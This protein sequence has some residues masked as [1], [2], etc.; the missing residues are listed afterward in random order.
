[1][2]IKYYIYDVLWTAP[3]NMS[4][5]VSVKVAAEN[6]TWSLNIKYSV[7][8]NLY[9]LLYCHLRLGDAV[10]KES[11]KTR[12]RNYCNQHLQPLT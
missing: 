4:T 10:K 9:I 8:H 11:H 1:M 3:L 7:V 2:L 12:Q 6:K 5:V